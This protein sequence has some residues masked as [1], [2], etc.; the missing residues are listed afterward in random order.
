M[1]STVTGP[2][3]L[4]ADTSVLTC[5]ANDVGFEWIFARQV[6]ALARPGDLLVGISTSGRSPNLVRAFEA[7]KGQGVHT[8]AILGRDGGDLRQLA[9]RSVVVPSSDTQRIQ[10]IHSLV[11]HLICE[12]AEE[13]LFSAAA[14]G[15]HAKYR[16]VP[17]APL[18]A[19]G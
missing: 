11:L 6:E 3:S 13:L 14:D 12:L 17:T 2:S 16:I 19:T 15:H 1:R 4:T 5:W 7:A 9:E 10:E 18:A 8:L